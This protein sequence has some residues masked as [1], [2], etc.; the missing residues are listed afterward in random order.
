LIKLSQRFFSGLPFQAIDAVSKY[1]D[2]FS[3]QTRNFLFDNI[4]SSS[5]R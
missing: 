3:G 4:N 5:L 1:A 2:R